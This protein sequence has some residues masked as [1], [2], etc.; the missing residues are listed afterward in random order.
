[1]MMAFKKLVRRFYFILVVLTAFPI[2]FLCV[3]VDGHVETASSVYCFS[4]CALP[5]GHVVSTEDCDFGL[6]CLD[7]QHVPVFVGAFDQ[8]FFFEPKTYQMPAGIVELEEKPCMPA[9]LVAGG[10]V[11]D[12]RGFLL[13]GPLE[14]LR[15]VVLII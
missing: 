13:S 11:P 10:G 14:A 12:N 1:M 9:T 2:P 4:S 8:R 7:C 6:P 3:G 5:S 15:Q